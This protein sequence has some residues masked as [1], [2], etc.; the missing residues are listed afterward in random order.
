[1]PIIAAFRRWPAR[2]RCAV[3]ARSVRNTHAGQ[4][5]T[6]SDEEIAE[7]L[8][9]VSIPMLMLSLVHM[10]GDPTLIRGAVKP[11]GLFLNEVQGYMS[12]DDK[13]A[14]RTIALEVI[15]DYRDRGCPE[16]A[17]IGPAQL[18]PTVQLLPDQR[19]RR[20]QGRECSACPEQR[21]AE[22]VP[23]P[24]TCR[25]H[26]QHQTQQYHLEL[27]RDGNPDRQAEHDEQTIVT[28]PLPSN[29]QPQQQHPLQ[30]FERIRRQPVSSLSR[31]PAPQR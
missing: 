1:M 22:Q 25:R 3:I 29:H 2:R 8:L 11:A 26:E 9:D 31:W 24:E 5:F 12:E 4:P 27:G 19:R 30:W 18:W 23:W 21:P 20:D 6:S 17:P 7:A 14:I 13:G 15:A 10:S 16:P 28:Q